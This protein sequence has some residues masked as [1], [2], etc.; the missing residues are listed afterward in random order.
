MGQCN[1]LFQA[2]QTQGEFMLRSFLLV[3]GLAFCSSSFAKIT[4]N[5]AGASFPYLI[6]SKWFSE[7]SKKNTD[8]Q[9][10]YNAIGSGRGIRQLLKELID[11]GASDAPMK[12]KQMRKVKYTIHHIPTVLGAVAVTYNV[13]EITSGLKLTGA[14][15]A[16][17]FQGKITK[18]NDDV[19]QTLNPQMNLPKKNILRVTRADSS[20][21]TSIFS[22]FL[23]KVNSS[24]K[25]KIGQG[26]KLRWPRGT[27]SGKGNDGVTKLVKQT[28]GAIGYMELAYAK[29][30][31][32]N[33]IAVRNQAREYIVP[34]VKGISLSAASLKDFKGD[35]R[36]SITNAPGKGVYPISAFSYIL[37]PAKE[38]PK[39]V[40]VKKFLRWALS[41]GQTFASSLHYAPLP[42]NLA[43]ALQSFLIVSG[44]E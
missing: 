29:N 28:D 2:R 44:V 39:L 34:S 17:I 21:T 7:Y 3:L 4:V 19:I 12:D 14:V 32:L 16:D 37:L 38:N 18:W 24:F 9:F 36:I 43:K 1:A 13:K 30:N 31:K 6:Y 41:E 15:I 8:V 35:L 25:E 23:S 26:K 10:N 11:F 40:E 22:D 5:G 33:V 20:G 42:H 27:L